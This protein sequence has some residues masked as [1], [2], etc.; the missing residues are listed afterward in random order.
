MHF[1]AKW[2]RVRCKYRWKAAPSCN[3]KCVGGFPQE[4]GTLVSGIEQETL[5][6]IENEKCTL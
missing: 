4:M 3:G 5:K 1:L 2:N 6:N